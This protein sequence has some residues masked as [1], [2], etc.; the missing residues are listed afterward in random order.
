MLKYIIDN[1]ALFQTCYSVARIVCI[2]IRNT[3]S[4]DDLSLLHM[5]SAVDNNYYLGAFALDK[6]WLNMQV[7]LV[8]IGFYAVNQS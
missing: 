1:W 2:V 5:L 4:A 7:Y 3:D 8:K 6:R